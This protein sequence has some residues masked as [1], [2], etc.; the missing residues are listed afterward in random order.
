MTWKLTG[1]FNIQTPQGDYVPQS[2]D[3]AKEFKAA[4][5][6]AGLKEFRVFIDGIEIVDPKNLPTNSVEA[7]I[8]QPRIEGV[9][10]ARVAGYDVAGC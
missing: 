2:N 10:K 4:A 6:S 3:L 1:K 8:A 9:A 7:L 5:V